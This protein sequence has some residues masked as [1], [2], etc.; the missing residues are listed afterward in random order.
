MT[1]EVGMGRS[2]E[3]I[4][5]TGAEWWTPP[6]ENR[7]GKI[8]T[9]G[10]PFENWSSYQLIGPKFATVQMI[11]DLIRV[12]KSGMTPLEWVSLWGFPLNLGHDDVYKQ[13]GSR[14]ATPKA[15][16]EPLEV[17][18]LASKVAG[19]AK[20]LHSSLY[21]EESDYA[22]RIMPIVDVIQLLNTQLNA[23]VITIHPRFEQSADGTLT[24]DSTGTSPLTMFMRPDSLQQAVWLHLTWLGT[25][26]ITANDWRN[27]D[28]CGTWIFPMDKRQRFCLPHRH[29]ATASSFSKCQQRNNKRRQRNHG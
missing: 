13:R 22:G 27:C 10:A 24:F 8:Q 6:V 20:T 29:R 17:L 15:S 9:T 26:L 7:G 3:S 11:S 25:G 4:E 2:A 5:I 16:C 1:D 18:E 14:L 21:A 23:L 28:E 19:A 12:D